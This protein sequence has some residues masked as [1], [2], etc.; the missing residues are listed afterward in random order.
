MSDMLRL[1]LELD[2]DVDGE[3]AGFDVWGV[4]LDSCGV[5]LDLD[6]DLRDEVSCVYTDNS[7]KFVKNKLFALESSFWYQTE[8]ER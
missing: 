2:L 7:K 3:S 6:L 1:H 4:D 8:V 5:D